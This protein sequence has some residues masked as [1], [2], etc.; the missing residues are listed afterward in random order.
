MNKG[1]K[2]WHAITITAPRE[3]N[4]W[5]GHVLFELGSVG[6][7][8]ETTPDPTAIAM[9]GYFPSEMGSSAGLTQNILTLLEEKGITPISHYSATIKIQNWAEAAQQMFSPIKILDDVTIISPWSEYEPEKGEKTIVINPGMAFGTG[10][11]ATTK[12]AARLMNNVILENRVETMCDVGSGSGIL[13]IVAAY[14]GVSEVDAVEI[15]ADA[16]DSS[17]ENINK[18]GFDK[19]IVVYP[20]LK[21]MKRKYDL[22][23]ANILFSII[24]NLKNELLKRVKDGGRLVVS[25]ITTEEDRK[26]IQHFML[27]HLEL[28]D[29]QELD[30]WMGYVF[31]VLNTKF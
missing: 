4:D 14:K 23:V 30:G 18:N 5:L 26:L 3:G 22:V 27:P 13:S 19:K 7:I 16:R 9:K 6:N 31:K 29:R 24:S 21:K 2:S 20:D 17:R 11:H 25:G 8:E 10:Y 15:D 12:L 28:S 1:D